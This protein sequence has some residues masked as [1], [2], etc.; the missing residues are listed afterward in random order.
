MRKLVF[1]AMRNQ[2]KIINYST[3]LRLER[4]FLVELFMA[5]T[6]FVICLWLLVFMPSIL[7]ASKI[8]QNKAINLF[9]V[10]YAM[11]KETAFFLYP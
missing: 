8:L 4:I 1:Y 2:K 11:P 9:N 7:N 6:T 5:K 10:H 3:L